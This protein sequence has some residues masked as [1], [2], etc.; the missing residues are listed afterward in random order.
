[1]TA[2]KVTLPKWAQQEL[3]RIES[4]EVIIAAVQTV[5]VEQAED[6]SCL[7]LK[8]EEGILAGSGPAPPRKC[9]AYS[10]RNLDGW[11]VKRR[12]LPK[13]DRDISHY[14]PSWHGSGSHLVSRTIKAFPVE[15]HSAKVLTVSAAILH[16]L[17]GGAI[18]RFRI[19]QAL[20][21][22]NPEFAADAMFNL[23][24][25]REL[26]GESHLFA[27]DLSDADFAR[28]QR[29]DWELLPPGSADCVLA[30]LA[31]SPRATP[32][33]LQVAESRL[34]L[35]DRL[36]HDGYI[37]GAGSFARYFGVQFG[38]D[39]VA[40]ENLEYGNALYVFEAD[41]QRK[42]QLSRSEL[43]R[44]RDLGVHRIPH[45]KGWQ[46]LI[47]KILERTTRDRKQARNGPS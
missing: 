7:G 21:R 28:I 29:V 8:L 3:K 46:T 24:L 23:R 1:M 19:D 20:H 45:V 15:H 14:A 25:L 13:I 42:S 47:R 4:K 27:A 6:F 31:A 39:L 43:I 44:R 38:A 12:D 37:L 18:V 36:G 9:G 30:R 26:V 5:M 34:Q 16:P 35:L 33:R 17:K 40:L 10:R 32:E 2:R 22:D 41:W 11:T